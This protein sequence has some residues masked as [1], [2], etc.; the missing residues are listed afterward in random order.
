MDAGHYH[1]RTNG[2][3]VF[4]DERNVHPQCTGCNRF[5]HGNLTSYAVS[6]RKKYGG[7]ILEELDA[8]R[9]TIRKISAV[10]YCELIETYQEKLKKLTEPVAFRDYK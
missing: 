7:V 9:Q 1:P 3:A 10:E 5:R 8:L 4:F 2:L 6:L